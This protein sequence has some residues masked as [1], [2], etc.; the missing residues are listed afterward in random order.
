MKN[1][2][3]KYGEPIKYVFRAHYKFKK[4]KQFVF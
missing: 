3:E 2:I 4:L 1:C